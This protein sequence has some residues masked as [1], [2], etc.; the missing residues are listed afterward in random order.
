MF[1]LEEDGNSIRHDSR[2]GV[3]EA[4]PAGPG[5]GQPPDAD[6]TSMPKS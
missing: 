4:K 5:T 1:L 3:N 2:D 6:L